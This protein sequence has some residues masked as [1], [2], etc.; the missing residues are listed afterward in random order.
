MLK[1]ENVVHKA[2]I[3]VIFREL[4]AA[5]A[6]ILMMV[7]V[8]ATGIYKNENTKCC[9]SPTLHSSRLVVVMAPFSPLL[10]LQRCIYTR[11]QSF[12]KLSLNRVSK[13]LQKMKKA[14]QDVLFG[15]SFLL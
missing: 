3:I 15:L 4:T 12:L 13:Q 7:N 10:L 9:N 8:K 11:K 1:S 5:R 2:E 14:L 6:K